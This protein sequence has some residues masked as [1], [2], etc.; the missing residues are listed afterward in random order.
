MKISYSRLTN[1]KSIFNV[2]NKEGITEKATGAV[3]CKCINKLDFP[4]SNQCQITNIIYKAKTTS[5]LRNYLGKTY[6]GTSKGTFKQQYENHKK[7]FNHEKHTTETELSKE[8]WIL[9]ELKAHPQV[10]FYVIK[11]GRPTK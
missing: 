8:H 2:H 6:Y 4:L 7:S 9:K 5:D 3:S 10:E 1:I 11:R